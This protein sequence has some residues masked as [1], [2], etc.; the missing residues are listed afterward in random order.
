[1]VKRRVRDIY[2]NWVWEDDEDQS[3]SSTSVSSSN[4]PRSE[5]D[6]VP[7]F[8]DQNEVIQLDFKDYVALMFAALQTI[9]LPVVI[10]IAVLFVLALIFSHTI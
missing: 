2:G 4:L 3:N 8:Q 10:I 7:K 6:E 9:F 5:K 1:L